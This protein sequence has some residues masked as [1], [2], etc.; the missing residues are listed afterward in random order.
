MRAV[1]KAA[2]MVEAAAVETGRAAA[3]ATA[4]AA[5]VRAGGEPQAENARCNDCC[6]ASS[7][8][9]LR[10]DDALTVDRYFTRL[11]PEML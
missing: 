2:A 3:A 9:V 11:F 8:R 7:H 10:I 4:E 6:A 5:R 1:V